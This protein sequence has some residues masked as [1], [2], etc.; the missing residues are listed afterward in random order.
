MDSPNPPRS[1]LPPRRALAWLR[2]QVATVRTAGSS[3]LGSHPESW[4]GSPGARRWLPAQRALTA[5]G[6]CETRH[7]AR[8]TRRPAPKHL[9]RPPRFRGALRSRGAGGG[10]ALNSSHRESAV[11]PWLGAHELGEG[12]RDFPPEP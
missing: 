4:P 8:G 12:A 11:L 10:R 2:V 6:L 3:S 9:R 1:V 7:A 5:P